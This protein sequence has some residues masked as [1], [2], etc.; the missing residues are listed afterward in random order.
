ALMW[1]LLFLT[2]VTFL[3]VSVLLI[4]SRV[5][6]RRQRRGADRADE[7]G[8]LWVYLVPALNEEVTIGD[9]V[10]RLV[11]VQATHKLIVVIDD[12][13]DD[14]TPVILARIAAEVP[15]L[16]VLRREL[17]N[18]RKG[19]SAGLD[20]A[21]QFLHDEVLAEARYAHWPTER[22]IVAVVDA[23]GRILPDAPGVLAGVFGDDRVGGCQCL[24][25]IYNRGRFLT[26][27]QDVEFGVTA[28]AYQ[29]GR[30]AL[31]TAN[32]GGNSQYMRLKTLDDIAVTDGLPDGISQGPW[33]DRLTEDQD[34]GVRALQ[35][36]W[37]GAHTVATSVD[38]QGVTSV[39]RLFRQRVRWAQGAWQCVPLLRGVG[40]V[41]TS[42]FGTFD[43]VVYLVM[44]V[45]EFLLGFGFTLSLVLWATGAVP[46]FAAWWPAVVF[47]L[48][49]G[50]FPSYVALVAAFG[51]GLR[52]WLLAVV[53]LL[54]YIAYTWLIWPSV[55]L[56]LAR[57]LFGIR[58][59]AKTV[60]EPLD[61][62]LPKGIVVEPG[63]A[64]LADGRA[65]EVAGQQQDHREVEPRSEPRRRAGGGPAGP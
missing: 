32:M 13:S 29:L 17:P 30:S 4:L 52:S 3:T 2:V 59:W 7:A 42:A 34:I 51:G 64:A 40:R 63:P 48:L 23:D 15:D 38:Q 9:S 11:D 14:Q 65:G 61:A 18:G 5:E 31:G 49:I 1:V 56:S 21:W 44:P 55:P 6:L 37:R 35:A 58:G 39:R 46:Y 20:N 53:A 24:V 45:I 12:A 54:P 62:N 16:R 27:A 50:L 43:H 47:F 10:R 22:V 33:R 26:W 8:Y 36:G 60:R 19:K 28:Y 25:R 41:R 57:E